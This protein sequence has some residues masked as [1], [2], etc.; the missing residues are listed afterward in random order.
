MIRRLVQAISGLTLL[1][2]FMP[3]KANIFDWSVGA[4][5]LYYFVRITAVEG[6]NN[7]V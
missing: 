4:L 1:M 5:A 6:T 2:L 7:D 3:E